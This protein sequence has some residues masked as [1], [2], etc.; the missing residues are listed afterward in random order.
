[1]TPEQPHRH[2]K[3]A[4]AVHDGRPV[5][6]ELVRSG[7]KNPRILAILAVSTLAAAVLLL[8]LW[9]LTNGVFQSQNAET[10]PE[11]AAAQTQTFAGESQ[12]PPAADAPT[13][14][15]GRAVP[16]PTGEAPNVNAPTAPSN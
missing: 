4:D 12:T 3:V 11:A 7:R 8:G 2:D 5:D 16:T 15:T 6:P 14:E 10:G 9:I 1:M 13:D